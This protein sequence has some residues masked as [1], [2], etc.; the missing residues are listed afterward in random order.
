M[1]NSLKCLVMKKNGFFSTS[2]RI[3]EPVYIPWQNIFRY[4]KG[5]MLM[6]SNSISFIL[7]FSIDK[8]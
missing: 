7:N 5:K 1:L 3:L 6:L 4:F 8:K 2:T